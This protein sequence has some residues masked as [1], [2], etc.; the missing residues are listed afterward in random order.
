M[1]FKKILFIEEA[2][3]FQILLG[4]F[5]HAAIDFSGSGRG[6]ENRPGPCRILSIEAHG[7]PTIEMAPLK[8]THLP[9]GESDQDQASCK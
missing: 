1:A 2:D 5:A 7:L 6:K 8:G 4:I 9:D 3:A